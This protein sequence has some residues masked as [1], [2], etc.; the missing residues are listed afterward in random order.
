VSTDNF[1][2]LKNIKGDPPGGPGHRVTLVVP[3]K[4]ESGSADAGLAAGNPEKNS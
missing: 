4:E 3:D 2:A 1:G